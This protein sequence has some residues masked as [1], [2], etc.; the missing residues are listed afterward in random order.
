MYYLLDLERTLKMNVPTFW[1]Y[2]R[3]GY[4]TDIGEAGMYFEEDAKS[5]VKSDIEGKTIMVEC[6]VVNRILDR[7]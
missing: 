6:E 4:T 3:K 5:I 2:N 7:V 1:K